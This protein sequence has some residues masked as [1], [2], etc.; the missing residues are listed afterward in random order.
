[1]VTE[2]SSRYERA[3]QLLVEGRV[4]LYPGKGYAEVVGSRGDTYTV[5]KQGC[6]CPNSLS[7]DARYCYHAV[8]VKAACAEYRMIAAQARNGETVRPSVALLKA[9]GWQVVEHSPAPAPVP[10]H[11][12]RDRRGVPYCHSCGQ[13]LVNGRCPGHAARVRQLTKDLFGPEAA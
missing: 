10:L 1:M 11:V 6:N 3:Q 7:R 2:K 8:A 5:T 12:P 4:R 13:D 9:L